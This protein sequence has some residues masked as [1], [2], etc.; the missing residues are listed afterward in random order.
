MFNGAQLHRLIHLV[1]HTI[2]FLHLRIV[3]SWNITPTI[4]RDPF[5]SHQGGMTPHNLQSSLL[6]G[7]AWLQN[8]VFYSSDE[9]W[10]AARTIKAYSQ[11]AGKGWKRWSATSAYLH[12]L[13]RAMKLVRGLEH[14]SY[15]EWLRELELLHL[16]KSLREIILPFTTPWQKVM[17]RCGSA[18]S[19]R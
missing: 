4:I 1:S 19:P 14:K 18:S 7:A 15:E 11:Q 13:R 16:E 17:V 5:Y 3:S 12:V 8:T 9:S 2:S 10:Q 6:E